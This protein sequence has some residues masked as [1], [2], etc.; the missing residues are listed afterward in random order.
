VRSASM[1]KRMFPLEHPQ[2][3]TW[4]IFKPSDIAATAAFAPVIGQASRA[5]SAMPSIARVRAMATMA[6][7][8][9]FE[10]F[11]GG[12]VAAELVRRPAGAEATADA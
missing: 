5:F 10:S 9:R 4:N 7:L 6:C 1:V 3:R 12:G 11:A 8:A 2:T